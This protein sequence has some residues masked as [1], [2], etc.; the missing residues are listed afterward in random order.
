MRSS[1]EA[2]HLPSAALDPPAWTEHLPGLSLRNDRREGL[3]SQG[4]GFEIV[5][6]DSCYQERAPSPTPWEEAALLPSPEHTE[7]CPQGTDILAGKTDGQE[8]EGWTPG[9]IDL[10]APSPARNV[11]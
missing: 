2:E 11:Q 4:K 1:N 6:L 5:N 9:Q 10:S 7:V 3:S 8:N